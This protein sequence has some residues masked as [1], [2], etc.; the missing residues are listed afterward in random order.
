MLVH[1]PSGVILKPDG[2][3]RDEERVAVEARRTVL[4]AAR[5]STRKPVFIEMNTCCSRARKRPGDQLGMPIRADRPSS[6]QAGRQLLQEGF[7][8]RAARQ[9]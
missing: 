7:Y 8:E 9:G 2:A 6:I 4:E 5:G 1:D 3:A